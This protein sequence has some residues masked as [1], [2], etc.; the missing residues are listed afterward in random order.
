MNKKTKNKKPN[1]INAGF[2]L[3]EVMI[4][5]F[6]LTAGLITII[7]FVAKGYKISAESRNQIIAAQLAQEGLELALN[8]RDT[9]KLR[10]DNYDFIN[11]DFNGDDDSISLND[12][13]DDAIGRIDYNDSAPSVNTEY[14]L[15]YDSTNGYRHDAGG[16]ATNFKRTMRFWYNGD[17]I[18]YT[19]INL[20]TCSTTV[21]SIVYW[22]SSEPTT[23][24]FANKCA[25]ATANLETEKNPA[26]PRCGT[27]NATTTI[28]Y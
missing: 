15:N 12:D 11:Y 10:G 24:D 6:I 3:M 20:N 4:S 1:F 18:S 17:N 26:D 19:G 23:C 25:V 9:R 2:S 5:V 16:T 7:G 22:G 28:N 13:T 21:Y 27:V 14:I 8:V